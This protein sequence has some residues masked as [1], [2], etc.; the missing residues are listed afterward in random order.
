M[1]EEDLRRERLEKV[2]QLRTQ[3]VEPYPYRFE[4][5]DTA[6]ELKEKYR[7]IANGQ[8]VDVP[9]AVAGR[10]MARRVLGKLAFFT[11][12]DE[13][14][15]IQLYLEKSRIGEAMG[16][17]AFKRLD[18]L[19]D[20]GDI[21]GVRGTIKRT[22]KGELSIYVRDYEL[23]CK[24]LLPLPSEYYGLKDTE[25]LYRQRHLGLIMDQKVRDTFRKRALTIRAIRNFLDGRG[26]LEMETP[27]LQ[28]EAGGAAARPFA[29]HHNALDLGLY[30]RIAT[31]LHLKR[32]VV[33]GFEKVYELGRIFRN[34]GISTR[35]NPEFTSVEIYTAYADY[36][37]TMDL[38]E[39]LLRTASLAVL[40]TTTLVWEG[41]A[42]DLSRTFRRITMAEAVQAV[43]GIAFLDLSPDDA[44]QKAATL[45]VEVDDHASNGQVLY[46]IFEEKVEPTLREPTFVLDYPVEVSPLAKSHRHLPGFVERFE[47]YISGREMADGFSELND[48]VEQRRRLEA[49]AAAR[50]AGDAEAHPLDE[51]FIGALEQGLPPTGGVGIGI[52][53]LVMLLTD[54]PSIRDVIAFPTLRPEAAE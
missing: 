37:D 21:L 36:H 31:E 12:Q 53:R 47:L 9:V 8:E 13:S 40:G 4:R 10:I 35:H 27:V 39:E 51:D 46:R 49:Q 44:I 22:D 24:A 41:T 17:D 30:L 25:K 42:L 48:P 29:T 34:E 50:A 32:L 3:G 52:D 33:G 45:G 26:Y 7:Q 14:G 11:L 16:P 54:S 2:E 15:R 19:S 23:L 38:V 6:V 1:A 43:T 5:T 18:K 28:V 20:N